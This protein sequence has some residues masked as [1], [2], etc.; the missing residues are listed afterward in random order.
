MRFVKALIITDIR[1]GVLMNFKAD[2]S[3]LKKTTTTKKNSILE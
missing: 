1:F 3:D 2:I